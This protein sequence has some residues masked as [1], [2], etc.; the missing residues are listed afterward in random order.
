MTQD[1]DSF[2]TIVVFFQK[3]NFNNYVLVPILCQKIS[4]KNNKNPI[5]N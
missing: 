4:L 2:T 1:F 3:I 5:A